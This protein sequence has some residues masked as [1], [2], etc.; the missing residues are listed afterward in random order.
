MQASEFLAEIVKIYSPSG[1]E[2]EVT[3]RLKRY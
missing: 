2:D 1:R 3:K